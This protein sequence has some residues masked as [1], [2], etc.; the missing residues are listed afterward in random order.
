[1]IYKR[2]PPWEALFTHVWAFEHF[3]EHLRGRSSYS[4]WIHTCE[5]LIEHFEDILYYF[6]EVD[7]PR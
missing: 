6:D 5:G 1:M 4:C 7:L 2:D 3:L